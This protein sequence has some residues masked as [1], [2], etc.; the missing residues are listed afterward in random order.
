MGADSIGTAARMRRLAVAV[1]LLLALPLTARAA[2]PEEAAPAEEPAAEEPA[3]QE[4]A[5]ASDDEAAPSAAAADDEA[6][7]SGRA[8]ETPEPAREQDD[9]GKGKRGRGKAK[10]GKASA[11]PAADPYLPED[12][13]SGRRAKAIEQRKPKIKRWVPQRDTLEL[14]AWAGALLLPKRHGLWDS[15]FGPRPTLQRGAF[16]AGFRAAYWILSFLGVG[17]EVG[18]APNHSSSEAVDTSMTSFRLLVLGQLPF[19]VTPTLALGGGFLAQTASPKI[20][21]DLDSAFVWG[22]GLKIHA[23]QWIALRIDGRHIVTPGEG[24]SPRSY[25]EVVFGLDVTLRLRRLIRPRRLDRDND[26]LYDKDDACPYEAADTDDGCPTDRD[27]D[28]DGVPDARDRCPKQ[29][30]DGAGGCP[31]PD[32]DGDGVLDGK[33]ECE[34]EPETHNAYKDLDG[35]PDQAPATPPALQELSGVIE[36]I[37]F[38]SAKATIRKESKPVLDKVVKTLK[39]HPNAKVEIVGHTDD[40]GPREANVEL[41]RKRAE[42]VKRYLVEAG[43]AEGRLTTQGVGPD[44]PLADNGTKE[45]RAK[46]RRIEFKVLPLVP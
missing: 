10:R 45:G 13:T 33:D 8:A 6:A 1:P 27:G 25:G 4:P 36:G 21:R 24:A 43:I 29:W 14:G 5:P 46:N 31:I 32:T 26:G 23:N 16:T 37:T 18:G 39:D 9:G 15:G 12:R 20:L 17:L 44:Q 35:C 40:D 41:S 3:A 34:T 11:E 42:A 2:E 38:D 7:P 28:N 30:G 22:P 19:R